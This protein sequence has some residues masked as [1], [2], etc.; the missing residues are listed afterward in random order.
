MDGVAGQVTEIAGHPRLRA[1]LGGDPPE[2]H[3]GP[4]EVIGVLGYGGTWIL[5]FRRNHYSCRGIWQPV[6][7]GI[8][9]CRGPSCIGLHA[10]RDVI[11]AEIGLTPVR[12]KIVLQALSSTVRTPYAL[13]YLSYVISPSL[14]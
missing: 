12:I 10:L 13:I 7:V 3:Q 8:A 5:P 2:V 6:A 4:P 14:V 9:I 11:C 1:V